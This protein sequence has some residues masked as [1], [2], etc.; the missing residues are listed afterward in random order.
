MGV[1]C[2]RQSFKKI[3]TLLSFLTIFGFSM[4]IFYFF[5]FKKFPYHICDAPHQKS[6][7][8][9]KVNFEFFYLMCKSL[10]T[11]LKWHL[12]YQNWLRHSNSK[13]KKNKKCLLFSLFSECFYLYLR[14]P[15]AAKFPFWCAASHMDSAKKLYSKGKDKPRIGQRFWEYI[16]KFQL[17]HTKSA[18]Q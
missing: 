4:I 16:A 18:K 6:D 5:I 10:F 1:E 17:F 3:L 14:K 8:V 12:I 11:A 13:V 2:R 9:S 7:F 15:T